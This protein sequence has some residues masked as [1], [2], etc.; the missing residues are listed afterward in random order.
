MSNIT[1][2][3]DLNSLFNL[4]HEDALFVARE[5]VIMVGLVRNF[6]A[7]GYMA[8]KLGIRPQLT[9]QSKPEGIDYQAGETFG[10]TLKATLTPGVVMAQTILTDEDIAT[11]PDN[12][13]VDAS[14][15]LGDAVAEKID[16]D[17][18][19]QFTD[20]AEKAA[21]AASLT[22]AK[23]AAGISVLRN[24]K[25]PNPLY[26]VLHP[27]GW[28]DI[29]TELGQPAATYSFL[30]DL[31]NEALKSFYVGAWMAAS[32]FTSAN[33]S[34]DSSD[35]AISAVFNPQALGFDTRETPV[36][37]PE[38]DASRKVWELNMSAGYATEAIRTEYGRKLTHDATEPT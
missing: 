10:K 28:H 13:R 25:A 5:S 15:E 22:I 20:F 16:T 4:I 18:V 17:L 1:T 38:R 35:D 11:D 24:A 2:T 6:S 29:W 26:F 33:I 31:A 23:C 30:G 21:A 27:Y 8:R 3:S 19:G 9:A 14:Q 12:A 37:E 32:W 36:L 34:V 7:T